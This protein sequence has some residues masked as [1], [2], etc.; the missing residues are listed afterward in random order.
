MSVRLSFLI[1]GFL[2]ILIFLFVSIPFFDFSQIKD[3]KIFLKKGNIPNVILNFAPDG[4]GENSSTTASENANAEGTVEREIQKFKNEIHFPQGAL[5]Q[6]LESD[7][8]WEVGIKSGGKGEILRTI[9]PCRYSIFE[10]EFHRAL[11]TWKFDLKEG[12]NLIIPVSFK[13]DEREF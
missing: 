7:C 8:S 1:S 10:V 5:D 12:T 2:H 6:R 13:V 3:L 4:S 9:Q 11:K